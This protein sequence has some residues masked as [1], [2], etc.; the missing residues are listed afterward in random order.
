MNRRLVAGFVGVVLSG[1][2]VVTTAIQ[3]SADRPDL[4]TRLTGAVEV[5]GPGDDDGRG[6]VQVF[7]LNTDTDPAVEQLCYKV[8]VRDIE[9]ATAAHIHRGPVGVAGPIVVHFAAPGAG[10][11]QG[12]AVPGVPPNES[13]T[14][15]LLAE[16]LADPTGFYAN[17]HNV[18][19]PAG[20]VRGQ[21]EG[22]PEDD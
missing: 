1:A 13:V 16:I 9:P 8:Q 5:P 19:F 20:A 7:G 18:D 17:V 3:A 14:E 11:A 10:K 12:C 4:R 2:L 15:G 22:T 6:R 21:L